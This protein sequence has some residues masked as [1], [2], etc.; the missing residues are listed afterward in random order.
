MQKR[1]V[2]NREIKKLRKTKLENDAGYTGS[3]KLGMI[4]ALDWALDNEQVRPS[5]NLEIM[6][7]VYVE[8]LKQRIKRTHKLQVGAGNPYQRSAISGVGTTVTDKEIDQAIAVQKKRLPR[9]RSAKKK[10]TR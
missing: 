7:S 9:L 4:M 3:M 5:R 8:G 2:I 1:K 10:T 6:E